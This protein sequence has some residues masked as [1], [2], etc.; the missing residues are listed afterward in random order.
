[1]WK[2]RGKRSHRLAVTC[3]NR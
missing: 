2:D 3:S 1:M